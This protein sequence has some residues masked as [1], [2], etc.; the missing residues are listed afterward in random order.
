VKAAGAV[1]ATTPG[2]AETLARDLSR[3]IRFYTRFGINE[4]L[5][6]RGVP[7]SEVDT[8]EYVIERLQAVCAASPTV[9][10]SQARG[11]PG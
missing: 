10:V 5:F 6:R 11:S 9:R 3:A 8:A 2:L 4:I 7:V 1:V